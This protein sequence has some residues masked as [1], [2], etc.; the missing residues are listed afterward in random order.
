MVKAKH[1]VL[2]IIDGLRPDAIGAAPMPAL[3]ALRDDHW[4]AT[5]TTV[6]PSI[7]VA[8][9][10][11]LA[12]GVSPA[13][14]GLTEPAL[15]PM[16]RVAALRP[17]PAEL[18]RHRLQSTVVVGD[19]PGSKKL[20]A[21]T[22]LSLGGVGGFVA[23]GREPREIARAAVAAF[24]RTRPA[25][26]AV[27]LDHCDVAGHASGWMSADY[28]AAAR[29][30]DGAMGELA[31][32]LDHDV[33]LLAVADHGGGGVAPDDHDAPHPVNDAIPVVAAGRMVTRGCG[34]GAISLLDVPATILAALGV[35]VPGAYEGIAL[36]CLARE[37]IGV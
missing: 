1:V 22:L 24:E 10:T 13:T 30:A 23:S 21:R 3:A 17:L 34:V 36:P 20:L 16:Q 27:Y 35:P 14:H 31:A 32:L 7:T 28:L 2:A 37:P 29:A 18:R 19:L 26:L 8:A 11:S 25:F 4:S 33:L 9:L 12:T 15:P 6:R 5:G